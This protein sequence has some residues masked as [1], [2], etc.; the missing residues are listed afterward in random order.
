[1]YFT[2]TTVAIQPEFPKT[3]TFE[4]LNSKRRKLL[5]NVRVAN[6]SNPTHRLQTGTQIK[7]LSCSGNHI[8]LFA[9]RP[10]I[11]FPQ[12]VGR[13]NIYY[14]IFCEYIT[15]EPVNGLSISRHISNL[16]ILSLFNASAYGI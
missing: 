1:M 15:M 14:N 9:N 13:F 2:N 16:R 4:N 10:K 3:Y 5:K 6:A 8:I 12:F 11:E 7:N